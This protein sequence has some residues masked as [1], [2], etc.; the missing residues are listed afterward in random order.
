MQFSEL[1]WAILKTIAYADIFDYPITVQELERYLIGVPASRDA[2][3]ATL[4]TNRLQQRFISICDDYLTLT[5]RESNIALR[6][7]RSAVAQRLWPHAVA[8]GQ[9]I[10][11]LPF[12]RMVAVTGS[13][14]VDNAAANGDIDYLIIT[15]PGRLWLTRLF[16]VMLVRW[17]E[18]H[19]GVTLCPNYFLSESALIIEEQNLFSARELAQMVPVSGMETYD[20]MRRLNAWTD[21]YFPNAA[22]APT[23][24]G[25]PAPETRRLSTRLL[26]YVLRTPPGQWIDEWE[27][28]RKIRKL[29]RQPGQNPYEVDFSRDW[30][31]GHFE[32]H[33]QRVM[34]A[35]D[36]RLHAL[37]A[38]GYTAYD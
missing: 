15:E 9:V 17:A 16:V 1:E 5:G 34:K 33:M 8:Y 19:E 18:R 22:S 38:N 26:E 29:S 30:C 10:G 12:V 14:A 11:S 4:T 27:M 6:R 3:H 2:I 28:N 24:Y 20:A 31:K 13:L 36:A 23:P 32:G 7:G 25:E 37:Q 21:D 35:F